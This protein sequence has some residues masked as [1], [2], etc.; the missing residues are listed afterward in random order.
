MNIDFINERPLL[1]ASA[2]KWRSFLLSLYF[3]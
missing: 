2:V 1:Q 3:L